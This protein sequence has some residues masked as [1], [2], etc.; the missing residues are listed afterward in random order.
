MIF[1]NYYKILEV[2]STATDEE[3]KKAYRT[4]AKK[5]HPDKNAGDKQA[6]EKFKQLVEAYQ[7]LTNA[8][9]RAKYDD[10]LTNKQAQAKTRS[11][12]QNKT[13][14]RHSQTKTENSNTGFSEFFNQFF[15]DKKSNQQASESVYDKRGKVT[16]ELEESFKGSVRILNMQTEKLRLTIKPGIKNDQ[17]LKISGHGS[18][19][20]NGE[21]GDLYVRIVIKDHALF[22]RVNNDL[23]TNLYVD[24]YSILSGGKMTINTLRSQVQ[25]K[26]PELTPDK[27]VFRVPEHGMPYYDN[28]T[29]HGNLYVT[30]HHRWPSHITPEEKK[31]LAKL[32]KIQSRKRK[33]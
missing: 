3:L 1:Q 33:P 4:L 25:L 9:K 31:L 11:N 6:E 21:R 26:I 12:T 28:P 17:I 23:F 7:V 30:V 20:P 29:Q 8:D 32:Q 14:G 2:S 22:K 19:K 5:Y 13:E 18:P 27:K 16:I 15:G 10:F 24:I